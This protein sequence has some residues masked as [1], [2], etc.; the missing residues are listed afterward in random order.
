M[1]DD[2]ELAWLTAVGQEN[3]FCRRRLLCADAVGQADQGGQGAR[4]RANRSEQFSP[5]A[6]DPKP[7]FLLLVRLQQLPL[8]R[9]LHVDADEID[10]FARYWLN[11][12]RFRLL[13]AQHPF[14]R[15]GQRR[16]IVFEI[17]VGNEPELTRAFAPVQNVYI[18]LRLV[19]VDERSVVIAFSTPG[20]HRILRC[21]CKPIAVA[22]CGAGRPGVVCPALPMAGP[23]RL[24][25]RDEHAFRQEPEFVER[26]NSAVVRAHRRWTYLSRGAPLVS[27]GASIEKLPTQYYTLIAADAE[28]QDIS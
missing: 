1:T 24:S 5:G 22:T 7:D 11:L 19:P 27:G 2:R 14:R 13:F 25:M 12:E 8:S 20:G 18:S 16:L 15:T 17:L 10:V 9:V 4:D 23:G 3:Q 21:R 28:C 6:L 26:T